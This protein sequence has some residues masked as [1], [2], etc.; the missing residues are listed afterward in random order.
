MRPVSH[1]LQAIYEA[2]KPYLWMAKVHVAN[3]FS[4]RFE[5]WTSC[6]V[7]IIL[8]GSSIYF[9]RSVYAKVDYID[10]V[11]RSQIITYAAG[12]FVINLLFR[13]KVDRTLFEKIRSGQIA[14]DYLRPANL[15]A[16]WFSEDIGA[17]LSCF[18]LSLPALSLIVLIA[19]PRHYTISLPIVL[20]CTMSIGG[21]YMILWF[22][23]AIFGIAAF[24]LLDAGPLV[25]VKNALVK[26]LSG[27]F[28]PLWFF[29]QW[30]QAISNLL[31][32]KYICQEPLKIVSG[33]S[34]GFEVLHIL[35]M[36]LA[37]IVLLSLILF[38]I[39]E[40]VQTRL[41]IQGG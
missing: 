40:H 36:Q 21:G 29:P 14:V 23:S 24:W 34:T 12:A 17:A 7:N 10:G 18:L 28:I 13:P 37:W 31:P 35:F 32:F 19:L 8:L 2:M 3:A 33:I 6:A 39:W 22:I 38:I 15:P 5:I 27:S 41:T 26:S 16:L 25:Y 11:S 20:I 1:Y 30:F 9:W 4:S